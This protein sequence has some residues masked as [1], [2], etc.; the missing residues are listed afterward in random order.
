MSSGDFQK[1]YSEFNVRKNEIQKKIDQVTTASEIKDLKMEINQLPA[2]IFSC[3][4]DDGEVIGNGSGNFISSLPAYDQKYYTNTIDQL[5]NLLESKS[6]DLNKGKKKFSFK[7]KNKVPFAKIETSDSTIDFK[8]INEEQKQEPTA[9]NIIGI[10]YTIA[11]PINSST[12]HIFL[13]NI[14]S[15]IIKMDNTGY[16]PDSIHLSNIHNSKIN[17]KSNT[18][19]FIDCG[20]DN[21]IVTESYQLRLHNLQQSIIVPRILNEANRIVI[22]NC[23]GIKIYKNN[24]V[25][26]FVEVDDFNFPTKS[27]KNPN[28]EYAEDTNEE[29]KNEIIK[30]FH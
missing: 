6:K 30:S 15:S 25:D 7:N 4:R 19:I 17:I 29:L 22:E 18:S 20:S 3:N 9:E 26:K 21:L 10:E 27:V 8:A 1:I 12:A 11:K 16:I 24:D 23:N 28:F 2:E 14:Q 13:N 5:F